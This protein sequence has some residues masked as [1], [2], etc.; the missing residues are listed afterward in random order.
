VYAADPNALVVGD[1]VYVFCSTDPPTAGPST[2]WNLMR[3][4]TLITTTNLEAG[5]PWINHGI[6]LSPGKQFSS[7]ASYLRT[8]LMFAPGAIYKDGWFYLYFPH[9]QNAEGSCDVGVAR[10]RT[11][12][13]PQSWQLVTGIIPNLN[14][15]DPA[16]MQAPD[17]RMYL[18]GN[19]RE[20]GQGATLKRMI[21]AEL[22][23]ASMSKALTP[24]AAIYGG[25]IT[26]AVFA[27]WRRFFDP[28]VQRTVVK[29]Y[30][31]ARSQIGR[32]GLQYWMTDSPLPSISRTDN[33]MRLTNNQF[34]APAH[35]SII[36]YKSRFYMF[37]HSG[38]ENNGNKYRRS[39]C[40]DEIFFQPSGLIVAPVRLS[41]AVEM[42]RGG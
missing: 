26:E 33:G 4:Y 23:R 27:F 36:E 13:L 32:D 10:S 30:F 35:A 39:T 24:M 19:S 29:Y 12:T 5:V 8:K 17:G 18:Y 34:D 40:M 9:L 11:P 15:F 31:L 3:D 38:V 37:Y 16:V 41:C 22:D 6:I 20:P 25:Y 42:T 14:L 21:G 2:Q 7:E 1:T 28:S